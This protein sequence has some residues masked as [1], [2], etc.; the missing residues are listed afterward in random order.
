MLPPTPVFYLAMRCPSQGME[1]RGKYMCKDGTKGSFGGVGGGGAGAGNT[2]ATAPTQSSSL[3]PATTSSDR[4][5][6]IVTD[7]PSTSVLAPVSQISQSPS[8]TSPARHMELS[9][10]AKRGLVLRLRLVGFLYLDLLHF[11]SFTMENGLHLKRKRKR[12]G[13]WRM[14]R[15]DLVMNPQLTMGGRGTTVLSKPLS[16][17]V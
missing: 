10:G 2:T 4:N 5:L 6:Q 15:L 12:T 9:T 3:I 8:P 1:L 7:V 16:W 13:R 17:M 14:D 11:S